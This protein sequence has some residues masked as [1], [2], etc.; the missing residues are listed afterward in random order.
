M[1]GNRPPDESNVDLVALHAFDE[2][3]G[4][5]LLQRQGYQ[6]KGLPELANDT[7]HQGMEGWRV[8]IA[9]RDSAL[10]ASRC[11][12]GRVECVIEVTEHCAGVIE[13]SATSVRQLNTPRL[14]SK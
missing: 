1:I 10:F 2:V 9:H 14:A 3:V 12:P 4:G 13:E 6:R 7:R 11:A 5:T 8:R